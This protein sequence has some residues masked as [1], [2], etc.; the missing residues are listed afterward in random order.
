MNALLHFRVHGNPNHPAL[1]ML[2]G[3]MGRGEAFGP[4]MP[5]LESH[6]YLVMPDLP[7]H[8]KSLFKTLPVDSRP[9][10]FTQ[11]GEM[12][13]GVMDALGLE[14]FFLYGYSMG[15]RVAQQVCLLAPDRV[16]HLILESASPGIIDIS[17]RNARQAKDHCLLE[18]IVDSQDFYE[19]LVRW[20]RMPLFCTLADASLLSGLM[21][22]KRKN[23]VSELCQA[24]KIMG[25]GNH[26][27]FGPALAGLRTPTTYLY[28]EKDE[29]YAT[30]AAKAADMIPG[31]RVISFPNASHNIHIQ[32]PG[33]V[34]KAIIRTRSG[35]A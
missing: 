7:G 21:A 9:Q 28:G 3:F 23:D 32:F 17:E 22:S 18:G 29:K 12:V 34:A 13:L 19:F 15:G 24:L 4:V 25:V 11:V 10:N 35:P 6:F 5:F 20:H 8:G 26:E 16:R 14:T 1:L 31:L 30:E 33:E 27:G 2:H